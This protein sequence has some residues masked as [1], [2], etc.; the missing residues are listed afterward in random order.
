L[1]RDVNDAGVI[2]GWS[3]TPDG[4]KP[5]VWLLDLSSGFPVLVGTPTPLPGL[6]IKSSDAQ[7]PSA[8]AG[9]TETAPYVVAG[10]ALSTS[11]LHVAVRWRLR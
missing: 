2:V 10:G 9:V 6:G 3:C 11:S 5:T 4:K 8:A 7:I 1:A